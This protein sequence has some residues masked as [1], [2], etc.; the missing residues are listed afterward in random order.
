MILSMYRLIPLFASV[1]GSG[2][3]ITK[4][5]KQAEGVREGKKSE[6]AKRGE[7]KSLE[8]P[9]KPESTEKYQGQGKRNITGQNT[10]AL[11]EVA[12]LKNAYRNLAGQKKAGEKRRK[13]TASLQAIHRYHVKEL[14]NRVAR[15]QRRRRVSLPAKR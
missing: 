5:Q 6:I 13:E 15:K 14:R 7:P 1:T 8:L 9:F 11:E 2:S 12:T 10:G 4:C 3:N